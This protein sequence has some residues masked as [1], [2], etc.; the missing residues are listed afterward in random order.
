MVKHIF[1]GHWTE[2]KL[3]L[4][5]LYLKFY[6]TALKNQPFKKVYIDA[7]AGTGERHERMLAAPLFEEEED[8]DEKT[9]DGSVKIALDINPPFDKYYFIERDEK[10]YNRLLEVIKPY[11]NN[12]N[13]KAYNSEANEHIQQLCKQINWK[14]NRAV[15]FLDPYGLSVNWET[16][17]IISNTKAIDLWFLFSL[18]GLYRQASIDFD[19]I[20]EYKKKK[21]T[22]ILGT[23]AWESE[24]YQHKHPKQ[25]DIFDDNPDKKERTASVKDLEI[26]IKKRLETLFPHVEPAFPLPLSGS[27]LYSLFFCISNPSSKAIGL[28]KNMMIYLRKEFPKMQ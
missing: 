28:S 1:G 25:N 24:I 12:R 10:R 8:E 16:L 26:Y 14:Q 19:S 4:L 22:A 3:Q 21:I 13:L 11:K 15:L 20:E 2:I 5:K 27:Q 7:F 23:N 6:T 18:S 9:L 17:Q